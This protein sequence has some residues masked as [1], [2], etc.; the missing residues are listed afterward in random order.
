MSI[1]VVCIDL[2]I[3]IEQIIYINDHYTIFHSELQRN[4]KSYFP[5]NLLNFGK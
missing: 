3:H 4:Q 5:N 2:K 1:N